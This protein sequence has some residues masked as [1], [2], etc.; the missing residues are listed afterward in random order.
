MRAEQL[1]KAAGFLRRVGHD[2]GPLQEI[3]PAVA[4]RW[5]THP[6]IGFPRTR[7]EVWR[8]PSADKPSDRLFERADVG[9]GGVRIAG[10][11]QGEMY[12]VHF[13]AL[14]AAG[15]ALVVQA[16]DVNRRVIPGQR[17]TF[18]A[19]AR[20]GFRSPGIAA[21]RLTGNGSVANPLGTLQQELANRPDWRR[22]EVV[23]L[24]LRNSEI[25]PAYAAEPQGPEAPSLDGFD[26]AL[27]RLELS[28]VLHQP[29]PATG[30]TDIPTP[31]WDAP[32]PDDYL[33][34]L[35]DFTPALVRWIG[36][37]LTGSDDRNPAQLQVLCETNETL[38]GI[39]QADV[40]G[41]TP[42]AQPTQINLPTVGISMLAVGSDGDA[43]TALGYGTLDFPPRRQIS[44]PNVVFPPGT[45]Q[46]AFDYMVTAPFVF[47][48]I[49]SIEL[50]A[51]A[52]GRSLPEPAAGLQAARR[53]GNRPPGRDQPT[54]ESVQVSW[55]LSQLPQ[56]YGVLLSRSPGNSSILNSPRVVAGGFE[57]F[58]PIRPETVDGEMPLGARTNFTDSLAPAPLNGAASSRYM[59]IGRDVF[60]RWSPWRLVPHTATAPAVQV[61]GLLSALLKTNVAARVGRV[62]P[63]SLEIELAWDWSDRSPDRIEIYGVFFI[64]A[65]TTPPAT[66]ATT[67]P[68]APGGPVVLRF[69]TAGNP[70]ISSGHTGS[71]VHVAANP[72]DAD[73]RRY[74]LTLQNV[75]CDFTSTAEVALAVWARGAELVRPTILSAAAGPHVARALDPIPPDPPTLSAIDLLWT[76]LP[77]A[78]GRARAVL[79]WATVPNATGYIVWEATET[80][81]RHAVDPTAAPPSPGTTMLARAGALRGL[82]TANATNQARSLIAFSR[83]YDRPISGT[84]L[85][86]VLS[87]AADTLY[88][89]RVSAITSS[90]LESE[91]SSSVALVAVPHRNTPGQ[92]RLLVRPINGA[93]GGMDVIVVPG[94]GVA[95]AGFRVHRVRRASLATDMGM[96]G[97]PVIEPTAS[98]WRTVSVPRNPRTTEADPG[99]AVLDPVPE[100][101]YAYHYRVVAIGAADPPNGGLPGESLPSAMAS[102]VRPPSAPPLLDNLS[103]AIDAASTNRVITFRT[104]LPVRV[105]PV[106]AAE[107]ALLRVAASSTIARMERMAVL[108][109]SPG[110]VQQAARLTPIESPTQA[111][112]DAMPEIVRDAPDTEGR[113]IFTVRLRADFTGG[114][115]VVTDPLSRSTE[116]PLPENL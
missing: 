95:A 60:G 26:A 79:R 28:R 93:G 112:L 110:Q 70:F 58:I 35:R 2:I 85:E 109:V 48:F 31:T 34:T 21:L 103:I 36:N 56:S 61:P 24:P 11:G 100:S 22:I 3:G 84:E 75:Q 55:L 13:D 43:A 7:F 19:P 6:L 14:P 17:L 74:R 52:Q 113:C 101:W 25:G 45:V 12:V 44:E 27:L 40:P 46:P 81:V 5:V 23:G 108:R 57:P 106:G 94:K 67:F 77:D 38:P 80:A 98:A 91:R 63:A 97:P 47:P 10:W 32:A 62:V 9:G 37:C 64:A 49:G 82:I 68:V 96:M 51:L 88:A 42:T 115:L 76:A 29:L 83:L 41:A 89:Y 18:N 72:P 54:T 65:S 30:V 105:S 111:Q 107:I 114:V 71:V 1:V 4:L 20:G 104:D 78:T 99:R 86:V 15:A 53:Q 39:R 69:D 50:A 90:N 16:L 87:G 73:R 102:A 8:R 116:R 59:V 33:K 92:P 66:P